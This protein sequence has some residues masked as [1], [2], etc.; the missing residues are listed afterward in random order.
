MLNSLGSEASSRSEELRHTGAVERPRHRTLAQGAFV[1]AV[2]AAG[3]FGGY[4]WLPAAQ[5]ASPVVY[6][7]GR[8]VA[9]GELD[10]VLYNPEYQTGEEGPTAGREFANAKGQTCRP[11]AK[12]EVK[13]I[14]CRRGGDWSITELQ[15]LDVP[16]TDFQ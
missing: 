2:F 14:A 3:L 4:Q 10:S 1:A 11:F 6:E 13:G 12:G 8:L 5:T 7:A 15:Q 16:V 9:A